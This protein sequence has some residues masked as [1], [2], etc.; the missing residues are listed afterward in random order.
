MNKIK[1]IILDNGLTIFCATDRTKHYFYASVITKFGGMTK[2]FSLNGVEYIIPEG[3][4]H[5]ME[6]SLIDKSLYGNMFNYL[7][8]KYVNFNGTTS[9]D[10]TTFYINT[11][12]NYEENLVDLI[13]MVNTP[14]FNDNDLEDIKKPI[15][16]EIKRSKDNRFKNIN[17]AIDKCMYKNILYTSN[18]G[19]EDSIKDIDANFLKLCHDIFY[20]PKNQII[21]LCG[22]VDITKCKKIIEETYN[23]LN[24]KN[25][26]YK[27]LE[28][29]EPSEVNKREDTIIDNKNE[30]LVVMEYKLDLKDFTPYEKVKLTFY[31]RHFL[32]YNFDDGSEIYNFMKD[33]KYAI[34]SINYDYHDFDKFMIISLSCFTKEVNIFKEKVLEIFEKLPYDLEEFNIWKKNSIVEII[35][36]NE[37][38]NHILF[39]YMENLLLYGYDDFDK[40]SDIESFNIDEYLNLLRKIDFSQYAIVNRKNEEA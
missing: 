33:N 17:D 32:K 30:E 24:R 8:N 20:Q 11:V 10:K 34:Y 27:L 1:K 15:Y 19:T 25:I 38:P 13:K 16:E 35:L 23:S 37:N 26:D 2:G 28:Y 39:P 4:A 12:E 36:R 3:L 21:V 18:V 14:I 40:V 9:K 29:D 22:N 6:H 31:V 5:L 7:N